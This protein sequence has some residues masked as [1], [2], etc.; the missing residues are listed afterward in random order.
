MSVCG[1]V[2]DHLRRAGLVLALLAGQGIA[3]PERVVSINL[4]TD[5]LAMMLAAPGQLISVSNMAREPE[6]SAMAAEAGA[7]PTNSGRAE[8][9]FMLRPDLVLAGSYSTQAT[10]DLLSRLGIPVVEFTPETS[11]EDARNNMMKMG[12]VL[13]KVEKARVM[14]ARFD[15]ALSA[16]RMPDEKPVR[17]ALYA[18]NGYSAGTGTLASEILA[19]AGMVNI[20]PDAGLTVS[21]TLPLERLVLAAPEVVIRTARYKGTSRAE[22]ILDHPAFRALP[23]DP[24]AVTGPDWVCGTPNLLNAVSAMVKVRATIVPNQ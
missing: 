15:A 21:G 13:D 7:W 24:A 6:S 14:V 23:T 17:A 4:C 9:V 20:A 11:F 2:S 10:V 12:Q 19:A 5:Q 1:R 16:L 8:D 22:E 18:A 3:A